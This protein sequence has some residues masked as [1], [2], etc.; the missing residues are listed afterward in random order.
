MRTRTNEA[1][2]LLH[3]AR[4]LVLGAL[5]IVGVLVAIAL[6]GGDVGQAQIGVAA[7]PLLIATL[8]VLAFIAWLGWIDYVSA[9]GLAIDARGV[10]LGARSIV[11][12]EIRGLVRATGPLRLALR[13][14]A[15]VV[16][17]QILTLPTP[18]RALKLLV[19]E[20][21]RAGASVEP[22]LV[23]LAEHVDEDENE[24]E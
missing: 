2:R 8:G 13:T 16:R 5:G 4:L 18:V 12:T 7:V 14:R 20:S 23:R 9:S 24:P 1:L 6:A 22:Y 17:L 21:A 19:E 3:H 10:R 11:W 15:G